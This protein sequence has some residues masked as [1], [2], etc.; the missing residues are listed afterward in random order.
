MAIDRRF[1]IAVLAILVTTVASAKTIRV[2]EDAL[3]IQH[4]ID[5]SAA[6]DTVVV[7]PGTWRETLDLRGRSILLKSRDGAPSTTV[8]ATG[9]ADSVI[10][11]MTAEGP[12]TVIEGMTLTGGSGHT[13]LHTSGATLGGGLLILGASPTFRD[14]VIT[15]NSATLN[16]G[17]AY[18]GTASRVRFENCTFSKNDAEKGGGALCSASKPVFIGCRFEANYARYA[19]GALHASVDS[20]PILRT[21]QMIANQAAFNGGA[22]C[23]MRSGG[24]VLDTSF[25]RNRAGFQGGAIYFG[26]RT[27]MTADAC[28]FGGPSDNVSGSG[29]VARI[30]TRQGRCDLDAGVCVTAEKDDCELAGG[31]YGGDGTECLPVSDRQIAIRQGDFNSDGQVDKTDMAILLLLWR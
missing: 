13:G 28:I 25:D 22:V 26:Y 14:C 17:G 31:R 20:E 29:H 7:A 2:P 12:G 21:C 9:L 23:S 3:T 1:C 15:K 8:D 5:A 18:I 30:D 6:G 10:R 4:A 16:G 24:A 19:G 11:C 27:A